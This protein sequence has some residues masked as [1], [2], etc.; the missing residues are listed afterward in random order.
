MG[1]KLTQL[2][3]HEGWMLEDIAVGVAAELVTVRASFAFATAVLLPCV[4][5]VVIAEAVELYCQSLLGPAAVHVAPAGGTI[6]L[7]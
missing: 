2:P 4:A 5:G 7:R 6:G 1:Q 3:E